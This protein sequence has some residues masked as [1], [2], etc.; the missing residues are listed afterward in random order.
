M[1][2]ESDRALRGAGQPVHPPTGFKGGMT[3]VTS[4]S[5]S[6]SQHGIHTGYKTRGRSRLLDSDFSRERSP[7]RGRDHS[8]SFTRSPSSSRS[9]YRRYSPS[10]SGDRGRKRSSSYDY[11]HQPRQSLSRSP[12]PYHSRQHRGR[13]ASRRYH[14]PPPIR[15]S[16]RTSSK[17][18]EYRPQSS[19]L[20]GD[21][22]SYTRNDSRYAKNGIIFSAYFKGSNYGGFNLGN[23]ATKET[24][25]AVM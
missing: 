10:Q 11:P 20:E 4:R 16:R 15:K 1:S 12:S 13:L 9:P 23:G 17:Y 18:S 19:R 25:E 3:R 8:R 7:S 5:P 22:R 6:R 2:R 24:R 14:S 21:H